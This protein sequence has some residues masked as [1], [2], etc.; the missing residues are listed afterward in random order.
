MR[1]QHCLAVCST[2]AI[3]ILDADPD[4]SLELQYALPTAQ[5]MVTLIKGRRSTR[6]Y[7]KQSLESDTIHTLLDTAWHAPTGS[8]T[9][10]VLFSATMN[11]E[12]TEALRVEIYTRL[13]KMLAETDPSDDDYRLQYFRGAYDVY[14][15]RGVERF[16]AGAPHILVASG[17]KTL[18]LNK[19]D[20]LIALT[21]FELLAQTMGV[22]T[23]WSG[24]LTWS[25]AVFFPEL[26][27]K[28]GVPAD[29]EIGY[30]MVFGRPAVKFHRTVQRIPRAMNLVETF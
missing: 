25:L 8:N 5:S 10:G 27:M 15:N 21:N 26:A 17:P 13:E 23:M 22:G 24:L 28:L 19:D 30:C 6:N 18:P 3:S 4:N 2:A 7:R 11:R 29:H 12:A 16:L 9:Q 1:C 20:C 14:N